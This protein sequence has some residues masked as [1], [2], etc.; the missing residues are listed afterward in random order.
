MCKWLIVKIVNVNHWQ[1]FFSPN[2]SYSFTVALKINSY[3]IKRVNN[4]KYLGIII[5]DELKWSTHI[6]TV[7]QKLKRLM[8]ILY[9]SRHKLPDAIFILLLYIPTY[10]VVWKCIAILMLR[11]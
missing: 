5:D 8:G 2:K 3:L 1:E 4:C 6:E 11:T 9:K 7:Q 10:Y